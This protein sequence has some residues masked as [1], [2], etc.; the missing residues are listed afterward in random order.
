[1]KNLFPSGIYAITHKTSGRQY[2]GSSKE[3]STRVRIHKNALRKGKHHSAFLQRAW[4]KY[5]ETD[6]EFRAVLY[7]ALEHL[8]MYEQLCIDGLRSEFNGSRSANS[9]IMR[10]QKL[11]REWAEKVAASVRA[12][13]AAGFKMVHPPRTDAYKKAVSEKSQQKW[14]EPAYAAKVTDAIRAAMTEGEKAKKAERVKKLWGDPIYRARAVTARQGNTFRRGYKCTPEQ[15]ESNRRAAR[16][17]NAKR[18][19]G[20]DWKVEYV[21]MYPQHAEDV[22]HGK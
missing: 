6:F 11:P 1:M 21:R 18:K 4:S 7:C 19:H 10:G 17:S 8:Q 12:R 14:T 15:T 20:A 9:P 5:G 2:I 3:I 13:Y 22:A 16:I